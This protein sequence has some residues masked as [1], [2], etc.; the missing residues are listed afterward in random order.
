[1]QTMK[2]FR[3]IPKL[4]QEYPLA[5]LQMTQAT[6]IVDI[7]EDEERR[8]GRRSEVD[9]DA[10][11]DKIRH[12]RLHHPVRHLSLRLNPLLLGALGGN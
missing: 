2:T 6:A 11:D 3:Q 10:G 5:D 1:M 12:L 9:L 7:E 4:H 8:T